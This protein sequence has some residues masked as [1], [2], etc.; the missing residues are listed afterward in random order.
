MP[1]NDKDRSLVTASEAKNK[2]GHLL[3]KAIQC[4]DVAITKPPKPSASGSRINTLSADFDSLLLR[5]QGL[6]ARNAM[7][8]AFHASPRQLGK[9]ARVAARKRG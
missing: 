1:A 9:T 4:G 2:V 6:K 3:E 8:H 7:K 5:M